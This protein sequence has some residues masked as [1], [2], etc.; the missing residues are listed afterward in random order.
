[1]NKLVLILF[2]FLLLSCKYG[3]SKIEGVIDNYNG[4]KVIFFNENNND[5]K[6]I[7][8]EVDSNG[9]FSYVSSLDKSDLAYNKWGIYIERYYPIYFYMGKGEKQKAVITL[10]NM[11]FLKVVFEGDNAAENNYRYLFSSLSDIVY[12][13]NK[14]QTKA[15]DGVSF[16]EF[17]TE[18]REGENELNN[19]L[20]NIKG[21]DKRNELSKE[22]FITF[23]NLRFEY[24]EMLKYVNDTK[25][26]V[27]NDFNTFVE[28]IDINDE[29]KID[30]GLVFQVIGWHLNKDK[31][32][33]DSKVLDFLNTLTNVVSNQN[34]INKVSSD[35][36]LYYMMEGGDKYLKEAF[37]KYREICTDSEAIDNASLQYDTAMKLFVGNYAPDFEMISPKGDKYKLSDFRGKVLYIDVWASWCGPCIYEIPYMEK[38]YKK[39]SND[40]RIEFISVSVDDN[41]SEWK[42]VLDKDKPSWK[43]FLVLGGFNSDLTKKYSINGI[44]RFLLID[45]DGKIISVSAP[46]PSDSEIV[47]F[48]N[49]HL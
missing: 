34:I 26:D 9:Q 31:S 33:G 20:K 23:Q 16:K 40:K 6:T 47:D 32:A 13:Y 48:I 22:Q 49:S 7:P 46:R 42:E 8:I 2:S 11:P 17:D 15:V 39:F 37:A 43:Q 44:P 38:L 27:D 30:S 12:N 14:W 24:N 29:S 10:E 19:L 25:V 3:E 21:K 1:M 45:K 5:G 4:E 35:Y 18:L 28:S 41:E 36:I